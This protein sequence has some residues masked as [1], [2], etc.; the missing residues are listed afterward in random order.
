MINKYMIGLLIQKSTTNYLL[1]VVGRQIADEKPT[2]RT[3]VFLPTLS[4][5]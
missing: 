1:I 2:K 4:T 5:K 3:A